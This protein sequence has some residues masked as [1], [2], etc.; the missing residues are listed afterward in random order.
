LQGIEIYTTLDYILMTVIMVFTNL[1]LNDDIFWALS[2]VVFALIQLDFTKELLSFGCVCVYLCLCEFVCVCISLFCM[3]CVFLW[4]CISPWN[5]GHHIVCCCVCLC[6]RLG[7]CGCVYMFVYLCLSMYVSC[8]K[9]WCFLVALWMFES[10]V[11]VC[12]PCLVVL[13]TNKNFVPCPRD[14]IDMYVHH[15]TTTSHY[16]M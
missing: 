1:I 5:L 10:Y 2:W 9:F 3:H 14:F 12:A 16:V 4:L 15:H 7:M 13:T 8:D 11:C 6:L